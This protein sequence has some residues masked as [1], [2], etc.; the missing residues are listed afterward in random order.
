MFTARPTHLILFDL[1]ILT[2]LGLQ[3]LKILIMRNFPNLR[4]F[5][6]S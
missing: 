3:N 4:L 1:I 5:S 6:V 2:I